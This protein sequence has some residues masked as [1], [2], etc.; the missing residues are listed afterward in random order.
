MLTPRQQQ[1]L[2][3][4]K[5][6]TEATAKDI[7]DF[8]GITEP[9][10]FRHL[11]IL[12]ESGKL[13][14]TGTTPRVFYF[15]NPQ[16]ITPTLPSLPAGQQ[17]IIENNFFLITPQGNMLSGINA[18]ARWC[19]DRNLDPVKTAPE[20]LATWN[21]YEEHKKDGLITGLNKF[22]SATD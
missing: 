6:K 7:I 19:T 17:T 1:I 13:A 3:F 15:I 2:A 11:K 18:F 10:V 12:V 16:K 21:K 9:A 14:K 4:V 5:Q 20:Y 8:L 22:K